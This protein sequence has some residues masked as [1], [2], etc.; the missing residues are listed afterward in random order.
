MAGADLQDFPVL[1]L[2]PDERREIQLKRPA[3]HTTLDDL[4]L[5][6]RY[7]AAAQGEFT[8]LGWRAKFSTGA[9]TPPALTNEADR[10]GS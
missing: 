9:A 5:I 3:S 1:Y 8:E 7:S 2:M 6:P 4:F 10:I